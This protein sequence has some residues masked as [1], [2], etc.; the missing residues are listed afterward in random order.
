[1]TLCVLEMEMHWF[2]AGKDKIRPDL[3]SIRDD[4]SVDFQPVLIM[5]SLLL[6]K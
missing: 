5:I 2:M 6:G 1:M 4:I 3:V